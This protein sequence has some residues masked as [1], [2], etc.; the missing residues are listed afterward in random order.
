MVRVNVFY[1]NKPG[2]RFDR[3]YYL[4]TH[5]PLA[6]RAFAGVLKGLSVE[7]GINGGPPDSSPPFLVTCHFLFETAEAFYTAF[8]ANAAVLQGDIP[9][10][11]DIEPVIQVAEVKILQPE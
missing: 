5:M 9:N 11:T 10:Y 2:A 6:Q 4:R 3:D 8:A 1:P 7:F